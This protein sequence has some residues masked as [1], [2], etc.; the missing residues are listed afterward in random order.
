[1]SYKKKQQKK[2][3]LGQL[4]FRVGVFK[5]ALLGGL[6]GLYE[7]SRIMRTPQSVAV[8]RA[9]RE[10]ARRVRPNNKKVN[11]WVDD[12]IES[13]VLTG[14]PV[15]ILSQ[16]CLSK[17]LETRLK[18]QGGKFS[19]TRKERLL[20]QEEIPAVLGMFSGQGLR[21][22]WII[23]FNRSYLD[24]GRMSP[25]VE[26]AYKEM[27]LD[28]FDKQELGSVLLLDWEDDVLGTRPRANSGVLGNIR[29]YID[30]G[31]L[32][33]EYERHSSWAREKVG[34]E[35]SDE[36]LWQDV[37]FQI[38]CEVE[39]AQLLISPKSPIGDGK[40]ILIPL[41][42]TERYVFFKTLAPGFRDRIVAA[43]KPNPWRMG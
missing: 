38:A 7:R 42:A 10:R 26:E 19:P 1:M 34:L 9:L 22:N 30:E 32:Q 17:Y 12:Y 16:W 3:T 27:I 25:G 11:T 43:L 2:S 15:E 6:K 35:Q 24:S 4:K 33:L 37:I 41:E 28:L 21:V 40:F 36:E 5:R 29:N 31:A 39:E 13:C 20:V 8:M 14:R 23:T 18:L